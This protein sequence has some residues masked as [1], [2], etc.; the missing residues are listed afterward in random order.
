MLLPIILCN[1]S[2]SAPVL[3]AGSDAAIGLVR[4]VHGVEMTSH[5]ATEAAISR[6]QRAP[7]VSFRLSCS[8][9]CSN[10]GEHAGGWVCVLLALEIGNFVVAVTALEKL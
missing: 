7:R 10:S 8:K 6:A 1:G 9:G 5:G 3:F 2:L 4:F